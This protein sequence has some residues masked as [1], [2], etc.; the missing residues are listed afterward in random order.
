MKDAAFD[1]ALRPLVFIHI[2]K[3][4]G[5]TVNAGLRKAFEKRG[6]FHLQRRNIWELR[7]LTVQREVSVYCGHVSFKRMST[8]FRA[9]GRRPAFVTVL[10]DPIDRIL[11]AY[12][13]ALETPRERWHELAK[14]HD[15]NDFLDVAAEK[16]PQ[17]LSGKQCRFLCAKGGTEAE[18]AFE[19]LQE[20][21]ALVGL[22][23]D[24]AGFFCPLGAVVGSGSAAAQAPK[25]IQE[26]NSAQRP[27]SEISCHSGKSHRRRPPALRPRRGVVGGPHCRVSDP[28]EE[29]RTGMP[30]SVDY[31]V[32]IMTLHKAASSFVGA[33]IIP[34]LARCQGFHFLD[35]SAKAF[36]A[37]AN[38]RDV[39][40]GHMAT[41]ESPGYCFGPFRGPMVL[42]MLDMSSNRLLVHLRD[43]RDCVVS[44]YFSFGYSHTIPPG[45]EEKERFMERR[46]RIQ[47]QSIDDYA[48]EAIESV[49]KRIRAYLKHVDKSDRHLISRYEDM[50]LDFPRWV[51]N[52]SEFIGGGDGTEAVD[53]LVRKVSFDTKKED[54]FKHKRQVQPGDHRRKLEAKTIIQLNEICGDVLPRLGYGPKGELLAVAGA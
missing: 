39:V 45:K 27:D 42:N 20:N 7:K 36:K 16:A 28:D 23:R 46:E 5:T 2:P 43:P 22:Q 14:S 32:F 35:V 34:E 12:S 41:L 3:T 50:V 9:T 48:L 26:T 21:F 52:V 30:E 13:Y 40:K 4:A 19:S 18:S 38:Y 24:M 25:P 54:I 15:I 11:S 33:E 8:V 29:S 49:I 53:R 17:F 47:A 31:S 51:R 10:R 37:G 1:A 44:A 6:A